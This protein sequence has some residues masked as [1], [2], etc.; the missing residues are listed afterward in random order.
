MVPLMMLRTGGGGCGEFEL[1]DPPLI[2]EMV[3]WK[4]CFHGGA[5]MQGQ[6]CSAS[7]WAKMNRFSS[8]EDS[9]LKM[10]SL[11]QREHML[12]YPDHLLGML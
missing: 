10:I 9:H 5:Y 4:R 1:G 2:G 8:K 7:K 6:H 11:S 3:V 12:G